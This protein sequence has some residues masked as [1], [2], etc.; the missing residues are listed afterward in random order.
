[1]KIPDKVTTPFI[2]GGPER[3]FPW[4]S[5]AFMSACVQGWIGLVPGALTAAAHKWISGTNPS[6]DRNLHTMLP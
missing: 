1:M 2:T 3:R 5:T 4:P 6:L